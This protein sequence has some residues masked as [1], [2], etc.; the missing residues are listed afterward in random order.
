MF[1]LLVLLLTSWHSQMRLTRST[2]KASLPPDGEEMDD[3]EADDAPPV[4]TTKKRHVTLHDDN[5]AFKLL[6]A[7]DDVKLD[8]SWIVQLRHPKSSSPALFQLSADAQNVYEVLRFEEDTRSWLIDDAIVADGSMNICAPIHPMFLVLPYLLKNKQQFVPLDQMLEDS[9][10]AD[11][12]KLME[13]KQVIQALPLVADVKDTSSCQVYRYSEEKAMEWLE[14]RFEKLKGALLLHG[15]LHKAILDDD[16]AL[17]RYSWGILCDYLPA[18]VAATLKL[19]LQIKELEV[20]R[21]ASD[22]TAT[23]RKAEEDFFSNSENDLI[24][25]EVKKKAPELSASQKRLQQASKG[26]KSL[27]GFF[28]K[29][30]S[31]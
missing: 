15:L 19:R 8:A 23:K 16:E 6:C 7:S 20:K 3:V 25:P 22:S 26:T 14:N 24:K 13:N 4:K 27:M 9:E 10:Y 31:A 11:I 18:D 21:A 1:E 30:P 29:Q 5:F 2:S 12:E 28:T 17:R